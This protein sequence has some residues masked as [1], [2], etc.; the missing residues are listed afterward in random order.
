MKTFFFKVFHL[1]G[2]RGA[3]FLLLFLLYVTVIK[4]QYKTGYNFDY[5]ET[6]VMKIG[7]SVPDQKGGTKIINTFEN[8]LEIIKT[9]DK[10]SL[11]V[12]KII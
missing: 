3:Y 6:L 4:A 8:A 1:G 9:A 5:S 10:L 2:V 7:I 11:G 12:P